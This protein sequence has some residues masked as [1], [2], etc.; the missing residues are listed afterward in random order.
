MIDEQ[1]MATAADAPS[2][3]VGQ[4]TK[5]DSWPRVVLS[6]MSERHKSP[7]SSLDLSHSSDNSTAA[8]ARLGAPR[9][10]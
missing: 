10:T 8:Q 1:E 2:P 4:S 3:S 6:G 5:I 7:D 9:W